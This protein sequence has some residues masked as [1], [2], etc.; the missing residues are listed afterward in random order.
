MLSCSKREGCGSNTNF[1][2]M[3]RWFPTSGLIRLGESDN[4]G[5]NVV[6]P[7]TPCRREFLEPIQSTRLT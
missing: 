4:R 5:G 7:A 1:R 2:D 3:G 6:V